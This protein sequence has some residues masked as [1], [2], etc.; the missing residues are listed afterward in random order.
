[1]NSR[2]S[3][4]SRFSPIRVPLASDMK[5]FALSGFVHRL[6]GCRSSDERCLV[7]CQEQDRVC[8]ISRRSEAPKVELMLHRG[9]ISSGAARSYALPSDYSRVRRRDCY[10]ITGDSTAAPDESVIRLARR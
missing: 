9:Y 5:I 2:D 6:S 7:R 4:E 3:L 1:M 10:S 8:D